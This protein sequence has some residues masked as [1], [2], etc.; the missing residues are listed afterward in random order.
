M[1]L[2]CAVLERFYTA[3][4]L[5]QMSAF[6]VVELYFCNMQLLLRVHPQMGREGF[7]VPSMPRTVSFCHGEGARKGAIKLRLYE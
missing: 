7:K 3:G 4:A 5:H 1:R 2:L 6:Y